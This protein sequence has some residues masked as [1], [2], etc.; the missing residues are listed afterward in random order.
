MHPWPRGIVA[1]CCLAALAGCAGYG[2]LEPAP[3][4]RLADGD[5]AVDEV[6][7]IEVAVA[8][9]AWPGRSDIR[10]YTTPLEVTIE[11]GSD[12]P[13]TL[14]YQDFA[15]VSEA[16]EVY[17]ALPP[18]EIDGR[19]RERAGT[20]V[21][22]PVWPTPGFYHHRFYVSPY[23]AHF[24]P[25]LR[26]HPPPFYYD[27]F[28]Y[29]FYYDRIYTIWREVDLPT[30]EMLEQALPEG[31]IQP[32]GRVSGTVYFQPV[33]PRAGLVQLRFDLVNGEN[34]EVFGAVSIPLQVS[35]A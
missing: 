8:P 23:Y 17:A 15:L 32:G 25:S 34:G 7:G 1:G 27:P 22:H 30:E 28:Y 9:G 26:R 5:V 6:A 33:D 3:T 20:A 31:V 35:P 14:R 10:R 4:A 16:G 29:D 24:Y 11:N 19:I 12:R 2:R 13:V 21:A 18:F